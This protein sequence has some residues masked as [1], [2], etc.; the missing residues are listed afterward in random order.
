MDEREKKVGNL[1]DRANMHD[2]A[3]RREWR[4]KK[5]VCVDAC[6]R[7][8]VGDTNCG[9]SWASMTEQERRMN[10]DDDHGPKNGEIG[11]VDVKRRNSC[12][13]RETKRE[14][15]KRR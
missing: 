2:E 1:L 12:E 13:T 15:R 9:A 3:R 5:G 14:E 11:Y 4:C 8:G 6:L 7:E 10:R